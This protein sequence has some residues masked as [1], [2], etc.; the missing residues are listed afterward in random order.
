MLCFSCADMLGLHNAD[1]V[2][3]TIF[4]IYGLQFRR[5]YLIADDRKMEMSFRDLTS[6]PCILFNHLMTIV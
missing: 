6:F 2:S 1:T 5:L 4:F 3:E